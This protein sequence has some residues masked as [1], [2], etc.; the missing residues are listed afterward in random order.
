[1]CMEPD[2]FFLFSVYI[3]RVEKKIG[4]WACPV[5]SVC[6]CC[7]QLGHG[8]GKAFQSN[9][10][11]A[12]P[13]DVAYVGGGRPL[14]FDHCHAPPTLTQAHP[15]ISTFPPHPQHNGTTYFLCGW[16]NTTST[17]S[18]TLHMYKQTVYPPAG[19]HVLLQCIWVLRLINWHQTH[20]LI[21]KVTLAMKLLLITVLLY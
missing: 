13:I 11:F 16:S 4:S 9:G 17:Q 7:P 18:P 19:L 8:F 21:Y 5:D 2:F 14:N 3:G 15:N 20:W 1:M 12:G 10:L 6:Q